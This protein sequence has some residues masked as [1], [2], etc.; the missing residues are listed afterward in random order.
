M[1]KKQRQRPEQ[2]APDKVVSEDTAEL[3]ERAA[4]R[5]AEPVPRRYTPPSC[6]VCTSLRPANTDYTSVYSVHREAGY[7][8]RYCK[9]GFC[10]NTFKDL[11]RM[12]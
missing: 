6:T 12:V 4:E 8:I 3:L 9:C 7:T 11:E 1:S 10:G 2:R 5:I